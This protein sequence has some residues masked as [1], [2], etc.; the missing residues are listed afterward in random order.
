MLYYDQQLFQKQQELLSYQKE[1]PVY[2][3][4]V[5]SIRANQHEFSNRLQYIQ[6]LPRVCKDYESLCQ[7]IKKFF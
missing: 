6:N 3:S 1:L 7:A 4:L 2:Q 5:D